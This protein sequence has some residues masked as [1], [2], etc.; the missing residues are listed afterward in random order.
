VPVQ[1]ASNTFLRNLELFV[2]QTGIRSVEYKKTFE[3][4]LFLPL[5]SAYAVA[6]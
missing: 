4:F 1:V 2:G 5:V 3:S 6:F